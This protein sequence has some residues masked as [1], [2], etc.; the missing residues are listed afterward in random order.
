MVDDRCG[1]PAG[2]RGGPG[3]RRGRTA[4][5]CVGQ[6]RLGDGCGLGRLVAG[7]AALG[8]SGGSGRARPRVVTGSAACGE[9][10][11]PAGAAGSAASGE[12][13]PAPCVGGPGPCGGQRDREK[14]RRRGGGGEMVTAEGTPERLGGI[15][16]HT[17][18]RGRPPGPARVARRAPTQGEAGG[19]GVRPAG[20]P[21]RVR[22]RRMAS[23]RA[24][25]WWPGRLGLAGP[26]VA[27]LRGATENRCGTRSLG[28]SLVD[29]RGRWG[30]SR[31][32]CVLYGRPAGRIAARSGDSPISRMSGTGA[33][34][35]VTYGA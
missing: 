20:A 21:S 27:S 18:G 4:G 11:S 24:G 35:S 8:R 3:C 25:R 2:G 29:D 10:G 22:V 7:P 26:M 17:P 34:G 12:V 1:R 15:A 30:R 14:R 32:G 5:D 16:S 19:P 31:P 23:G 6:R 28:G 33:G 9:G 13:A